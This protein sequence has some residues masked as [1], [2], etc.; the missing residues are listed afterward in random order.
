VERQAGVLTTSGCRGSMVEIM[1]DQRQNVRVAG[2][3]RTQIT[4][5]ADMKGAS[6][7][8]RFDTAMNKPP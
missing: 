1:G 4:H 8:E 6:S 5:P 2:E 7:A 3:N